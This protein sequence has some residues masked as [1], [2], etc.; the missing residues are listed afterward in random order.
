MGAHDLDLKVARYTE[1]EERVMCFSAMF[2]FWKFKNLKMFTAIT[3]FSS[4]ASKLRYEWELT[5]YF[6]FHFRFRF[7]LSHFD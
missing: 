6:R 5:F 4:I 7:L 3:G 2:I 1:E